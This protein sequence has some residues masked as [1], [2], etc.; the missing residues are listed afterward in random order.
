[1]IRKACRGDLCGWQADEPLAILAAKI[2][3]L[4]FRRRVVGNAN[5]RVS[6]F[7]RHALRERQKQLRRIQGFNLHPAILR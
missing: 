4:A 6:A 3:Q 5:Q 2:R 1:M 7:C